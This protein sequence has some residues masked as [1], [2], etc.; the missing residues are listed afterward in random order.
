MNP[1]TWGVLSEAPH[2]VT[3]Y[4]RR[5]LVRAY[6]KHRQVVR[7]RVDMEFFRKLATET[8]RARRG[9]FRGRPL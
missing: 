7:A 8:R 6:R 5:R 3:V 1:D 4:R 2:S 9:S